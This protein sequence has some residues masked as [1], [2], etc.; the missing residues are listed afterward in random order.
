VLNAGESALY[1]TDIFVEDIDDK[2]NIGYWTKRDDFV[3]WVIA[4]EDDASFEISVEYAC[5]NDHG[6]DFVLTIGNQALGG[7]VEPTGAW[8][9]FTNMELGK[10]TLSKGQHSITVKS[11]INFKNALMNLRQINFVVVKKVTAE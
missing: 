6:G 1:G 3:E 2:L 4:L 7:H 10:I 11:G 8:T 5:A 9:N